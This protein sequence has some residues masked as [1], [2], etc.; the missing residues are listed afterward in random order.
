MNKALHSKSNEISSLNVLE[1]RFLDEIKRFEALHENSR[2]I[3]DEKLKDF[4][5]NFTKILNMTFEKVIVYLVINQ[6]Y[7]W[8][9]LS[10]NLNLKVVSQIGK[11]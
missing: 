9:T 7:K 8:L 5:A 4:V 11:S 10:F 6:D 2:I 3:K 1:R